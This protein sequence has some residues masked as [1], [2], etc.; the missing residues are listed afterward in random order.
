MS[1]IYTRLYRLDLSKTLR[2]LMYAQFQ[3]LKQV[4]PDTAVSSKAISVMNPFVND[5]VER[6]SSEASK[7]A[8]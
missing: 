7:L 1:S 4:H 2:I 8:Q 3:V 5:F 6:I